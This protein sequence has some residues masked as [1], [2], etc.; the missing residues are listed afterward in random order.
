MH[1]YILMHKDV[2]CA[3]VTIDP[4]SGR[5]AEYH[6]I[7]KEYTPFL[8]NCD[9]AKINRWW[10]MRAVPASRNVMMT[11]IRETGCMT[12]EDYLEKNLALSMTDS[13]W[14]RPEGSA[15]K[16]QDVNFLT[17]AERS[18]GI[19]PYH[20]ATSY[21]PN[22]SLGGQMDKYWDLGGK[23]PL[24]VKESYRY[25]GQ[26]SLNELLAS[27]IHL[28][29]GTDIPYV[30]YS[31]QRLKD[32]GIACICPCFTSEKT[33]FIS[34]YELL[35][36]GKTANSLNNYQAY[37]EFAV[38]N[39]IDRE[40]M[41]RFMD[42][43]TLTDFIISNTDEHLLNFGILRDSDT[44]KLTGP[45]P[46]FDSG[47][48]MFYC[49]DREVP[50]S[51]M[52]LLERKITSF[53]KTE[54]KMLANVHDPGIIK[55]DLLPDRQHIADFFTERGI[56]ER[57]ALFIAANYQTKVQMLDELQHG[58][59]ISLYQEKQNEKARRIDREQQM[60]VESDV[61]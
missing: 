60:S 32:G 47:N 30:S 4:D 61:R 22:A 6:E 5:V 24:L 25:Y 50:Y 21:D 1:K 52:E 28:L 56:P 43:Q 59:K 46:I 55:T 51:R 40:V 34:A 15:L 42:Y 41:Q 8:G 45:A 7:N 49:D 54:E 27:T 18:N 44:M 53:Y 33:E 35:E 37:I 20:N 36:S 13:Y 11:I 12:P 16:Y 9:L 39:G 26:Q 38:K 17:I 48:S 10:S 57:K 29:Q 2:E 19:V 23:G 14:V 58:K 31:T 3:S